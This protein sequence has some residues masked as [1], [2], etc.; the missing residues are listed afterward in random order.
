MNLRF[1]IDRPVF[2][3]VISV[4]IVLLG[5][6]A[7]VSLPVEQYP[8]I[9]PPT[10][11]VTTSYPGANAETAQ[12]AVLVPLE[13]AINGVEN[14]DYIQSNTSNSGEVFIQVF[15]KQGVDPDMAAVNVQNRV[16]KA[17]GNLPSEVTK[18]GVQTLKQQ[19]ST[20][21]VFG[22]YSPDDRY[23]RQFINNYVN[24]NIEP[25]IK[26]IPGVG[27]FSLM[28][29]PYAM[30]IWLRPDIM[31]QYKLI[32]DDVTAA[33]ERQNL[34]AATGAFGENNDNA[35]EYTIKY[36]G[37]FTQPSQ[38]EN[39]VIKALPDGEILRLKDIAR[40]QLGD[41]AY[42]YN[43]QVNGHNGTV[44]EVFQSA[45]S[46]ATEVVNNID[47]LLDE[48]SEELPEGLEIV[49]L[50]SVNDFLY[51][52]IENV[53]WTLV[54]AVI[55]V[56]LVVYFFLQD[57]RATLI[58]TISIFVALIGTFGFM[59]VAGFSINL[60]TLFALVLAI[61]T[62]VDN[63][64]VVVEA[65]QA[66]FD[67]GY[68]SSYMAVNDA[69]KGITSAIVTST[70]VFMAVFIPVSMM[71]GTSGV[72]YTQ[73]GITMAVAVGISAINVLTLSP[74]LCALL[75]KPYINEDGSV[76][77]NFSMRFREKFNAVFNRYQSKYVRGVIFCCRHRG[78]TWL[79]L[80]LSIVFLV[81]LMKTTKTGL[82]PDEDTGT[83]MISI[84]TKAGT[85][86]EG[87]TKIMNEIQ[88]DIQQ[89]PQVLNYAVI[90]GYSFDGAGP[91]QGLIILS[92][93]DWSE[94]EGRENSDVAL[95]NYINGELSAKHPDATIFAAAPPMINGFGM[96]NGFELHLQN[97]ADHP[98]TEHTEIAHQFM[99]ALTDR[100]EIATA[101]SSFSANY[102]QFDLDIDAAQCEKSGISPAEVLSTISGYYGG[103]YVSNFNRFSK[104]Y[105]V[106]IQGE[107]TQRITPESLN[108]IYVRVANGDMAPAGQFA[109]LT[110]TYGP[111]TLN[112]QNLY[113]SI[114]ISG[115]AAEG[116]STG[117]VINAVE[118]VAK[119]TLPQGYSYEF[120]GLSR[121]ESNSKSNTVVIFAICFILVF[122]ILSA[123][124]ESFNIPLAV[125]LA[126]PFGLMGSFLFAWLMGLENNIYMQTGLIMLIGLLAK[127]AILITEY[128]VKRRHAG[129]SLIQAAVGSAK[130]RLRPILM[131]ALT[132]IFGLLPMMVSTG[133]G[134]N[135]NRT[136]GSSA[137]GGMLVGTIALLFI[138]PVLFMFFEYL[139]EKI[140][141]IQTERSKSWE[142]QAEMEELKERK[143][144]EK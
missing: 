87:T 12:K 72:F 45:G 7:L 126:I 141:P 132:M 32:P 137:V 124:Y 117:E 62:V 52:S 51:A 11:Q 100:P 36:R 60:L 30:R 107:P 5:I 33:I 118:E 91:S 50:Q 19:K 38:F 94:R 6:I 138:V 70:L 79:T 123:L 35:Y 24:I 81:Y 40:I 92:L 125:I 46:N 14:M 102:P 58:P 84:S 61:G 136:L 44:G 111:Q 90:A 26:R 55:L 74:A 59:A 27:E 49:N 39:I 22:V 108:R 75:M 120:G 130:V 76:K 113:G 133:V 127:T 65:V 56:V 115:G 140:H 47:A 16:S 53:I 135:G 42:T 21:K 71:G 37:R 97:R 57:I 101:F 144:K 2:S 86:L 112:R 104:L 106:M 96:T 10:V 68:K 139:Q 98:I 105:R 121:E 17:L 83:V 15:F 93:K 20:L 29:S 109:R 82:I 3:I 85:S 110:K 78:L 66:K 122:L 64:I 48:I 25:R 129:M 143:E 88:A 128:A 54:I 18:I 1:F 69:M 73:F 23:D 95:V 8:D 142:I 43:T 31:A 34:E 80:L 4:T 89:M 67:I 131:T 99:K 13:E 134:A 41:E 9:A 28:G 119:Q 63:A 103:S 114:I 116:Y 77:R